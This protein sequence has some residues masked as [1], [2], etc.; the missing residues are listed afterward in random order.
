MNEVL[1]LNEHA[2]QTWLAYRRKIKKSLKEP[3]WELAQKRM[4]AMGDEDAQMEAVMT[5]IAN[6]WTGLFPPK[7]TPWDTKKEA[8][9]KAAKDRELRE[10]AA[11]EMRAKAIGYRPAAAGESVSD[12]RC[13]VERAE[14]NEQD[15]RYR[16]SLASHQQ[17]HGRAQ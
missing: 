8:A 3:S 7:R 2:W 6:G 4:A 14:R 5:S 10:I 9:A 16:E 15:R 13:W 17:R 12:Y 11:L 1:G